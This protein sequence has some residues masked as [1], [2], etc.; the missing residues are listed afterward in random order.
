MTDEALKALAAIIAVVLGSMGSVA[1]LAK[2]Y[3]QPRIQR[4]A[5]NAKTAVDTAE[6]AKLQ[7]DTNTAQAT[8]AAK[9]ATEEAKSAK[10]RVEAQNE[11]FE[12]YKSQLAWA[13]ERIA[14][15]ET[16]RGMDQ[17]RYD[18]MVTVVRKLQEENGSLKRELEMN[19]VEMERMKTRQAEI[20]AEC[21]QHADEIRALK[22]AIEEEGGHE[23]AQRI[24]ARTG[25]RRSDPKDGG[26]A[27]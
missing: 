17:Q 7:A 2:V 13:F 11:E 16:S 6:A 4:A 5:Q 15:L 12:F 10:A 19:R 21:D 23:L 26:T 8:Q 18:S 20:Q 14:T 25:R 27:V 3:I 9:V 1:A 24:E 22:T